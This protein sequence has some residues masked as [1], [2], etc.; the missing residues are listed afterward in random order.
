MILT[1]PECATRYFVED[2][3]LG[4]GGRTVRCAACGLAWKARTEE[5]L[6]LTL[7]AEEGAVA[8]PGDALS[9]RNP[10]ELRSAGPATLAEV[11]APE[12]P[13]AFR[14]QAEQKRRM[15]DAA[16]AGIVWAGM[17]CAFAVILGAAYLFRM[18]VV[19][20]YPRA[21]GAYA[22]AGVRVNPTGLEFEAIKAQPAPDGLAAVTVNGTV[23]NVVD[24]ATSPPPVRV[25]L[26]DKAGR[27][28]ASQ[29]LRFPAAPIA[30]GRSVAFSASLPDPGAM[31]ADVDVAFA[32]EVA[33]PQAPP[34]TRPRAPAPARNLIQP[35]AR[36]PASAPPGRIDAPAAPAIAAPAMPPKRPAPVAPVLRPA[37]GMTEDARPLPGNDPYALDRAQAKAVS[38][39][40]HG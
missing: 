20:L 10:E 29:I 15:R 14:A 23:H 27:R 3:R 17:T 8:R 34:A 39:A 25:A 21:A 28:M 1:C 31:A 18:D 33:S 6:E 19:R 2:Q 13:R 32:L 38:A 22:M 5:P 9:F 4:D 11:S 16:A 30:P 37:L 12:L 24:H 7:G 36:A 35:A 26:I 40:P